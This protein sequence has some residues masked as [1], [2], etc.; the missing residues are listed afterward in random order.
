MDYQNN[1]LLK[2]YV[3][4]LLL[5]NKGM[6]LIGKSTIESIWEKHIADSLELLPYLKADE[7]PVVVDIGSGGGLPAIPC[8]ILNPEKQYIVT[9]V[10]SKKL[11]FLKFTVKKLKLNAEVADLTQKK[12][13]FSDNACISSRAFSEVKNILEWRDAHAPKARNFYLLKGRDEVV[14]KELLAAGVENAEI[15]ELTKGR[16]VIIKE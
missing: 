12:Y 3:E 2:Q 8:A 10:D 16:I 11:A 5:W 14:Q 9:E 15:V 7:A 4:E 1:T 13:S 6:N